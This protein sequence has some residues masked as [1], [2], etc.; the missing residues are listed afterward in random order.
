MLYTQ[1]VWNYTGTKNNRRLVFLSRLKT[2]LVI[3]Q[4][5]RSLDRFVAVSQ[6]Q[7]PSLQKASS[8]G[9]HIV[10][11]RQLYEVWGIGLETI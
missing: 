5:K 10:A 1:Q 7:E 11:G 2:V 8:L 4:L 3:S 9:W 6:F